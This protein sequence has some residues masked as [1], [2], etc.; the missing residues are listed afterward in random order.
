MA[1]RVKAMT[2]HYLDLTVIPDPETSAPQLLSALH[3]KLHQALVQ[4]RVDDIGVSFPR[5]SRNPR[6]LGNILRLHGSPS[7]LQ[8]LMDNDWLK[9]VR[10]HVRM[11]EISPAPV[12]AEHRTV[13]RKQFKTNAERLRR[14]R[15]KRKGESAEQAALAIPS[16]VERKPDLPFIQLRSQST[17]QAFHLFIALGPPRPDPVAGSFN[18]Y[19]LGGRATIPWF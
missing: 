14:R 12:T 16:T 8:R 17:M 1:T 7:G 13:S 4:L 2:T 19:G 11:T 9:G 3:S 5:Y 6:G 15:M 18:S 10:D